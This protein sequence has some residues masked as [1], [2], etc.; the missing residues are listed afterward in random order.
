MRFDEKAVKKCYELIN[1]WTNPFTKTSNIFYLSSGLVPCY[2]VQYDLLE[3]QKIGKLC[4]DTFITERIETNNINFYAPIK[5]NCLRTFEKEKKTSQIE[6]IK[7]KSSYTRRSRNLCKTFVDTT[8]TQSKFERSFDIWAWAI[9]SIYI[10]LWWNLE[11]NSEVKTISTFKVV[12]CYLCNNTRKL[13][14]NIWWNGFATKITENIKN[15]WWHIR[16]YIKEINSWVY[17]SC[18][19]CN[20]LLL[21]RFH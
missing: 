6:C 3:A 20:W 13:S 10:Q 1:S 9:A 18:L 17:S 19:F 2:E 21:R 16:L 11:E 8:K 7:S 5:K 14:P 12:Y 4:L 15:I